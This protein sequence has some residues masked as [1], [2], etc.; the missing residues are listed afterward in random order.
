MSNLATIVL[1][2]NNKED[3]KRCLQSLQGISTDVIIVDNGSTDGSQELFREEFPDHVLL[4]TGHNLGYAGGNNV[5]LSYAL[6]QK[7][8]YVFILNNDTVV[9]S[10][11]IGAFLDGFEKYPDAGILGGKILM[12]DEPNKLDHF[13]GNWNNRKMEFDFYGWRENDNGQFE[14]SV[15]LDY[16]CGAGVMIK[17]EVLEK[18]GLFDPRFFLFWEEAD[19]CFR[20]RKAGYEVRTCPEAKLWHKVSASFVGGKP[21]ASYFAHRNRLL[22]IERNFKGFGKTFSLIRIVSSQLLFFTSL[23]LFRKLQ[24]L[25]QV[26]SKKDST[27]NRERI[28]RYH[29]ALTGTWDYLFRR[30]GAG[31]S[32]NFINCL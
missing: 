17:R 16:V 7:Y 4:E 26:A 8:E 29:A 28:L 10:H 3:T 31:R 14:T 12:M 1:N 2:W 27:R 30:F 11:I 24:L 9:D 5:G 23:K 25:L 32:K 19:F 6:K 18:V 22:W 13:G 15:E 21:H 20:A